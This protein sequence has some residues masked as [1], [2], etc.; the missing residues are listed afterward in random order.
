MNHLKQYLQK[1]IYER[2]ILSGKKS[3]TLPSTFDSL[4]KEFN[5]MSL[6][7]KANF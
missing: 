4:R 6:E 2:D 7:D 5:H 3:G 1:A